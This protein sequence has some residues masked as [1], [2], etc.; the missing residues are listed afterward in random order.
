MKSAGIARWLAAGAVTAVA[1]A[2]GAT[3]RGPTHPADARA[4]ATATEKP[5]PPRDHPEGFGA[6]ARGGEGG[7][8]LLVTTLSDGGPGSLREALSA[9]GPRIVR[10]AVAGT[11][12]LQSR[13][14]VTSGRVTID[15]A[16]APGKG[17]TLL[18]HGIQFRGDCDDII[19]R[20]LRIRVLTGGA[21]GDA[22]LF[23]GNDGATVERVLVDHCSLM[24]A[25]DE[26]FNTW[27]RVRDL[28]CQWSIIA[29]AQLPHSK[30]W[31]SGV[32]S[33]RI[34]IHHCLFA[35]N[36]DRVPK[37]EG[38]VY[39]V[40]NN[41]FYNWSNNNAAKLEAGAKVN[42]VGNSFIPGP[43]SAPSKGCV[44]PAGAE[45]GTKVYLAGNVG[46]FTP[47]G[48]EPQWPNV[49][50]YDRV[51]GAWVEH[52]PAPEVFRSERPFVAP[53]IVAQPASA[54]YDLVLERAGARV[55]DADDARVVEDVRRRAGRVGKGRAVA[56]APGSRMG[57]GW[58][59]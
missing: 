43:Q 46:P 19:V 21:E 41:V 34:S 45:R 28:T 13:L 58:S 10:F 18:N 8:V 30:A 35:Q 39:D 24:W 1:L 44:F 12:A 31:L 7:C 48:R 23:W 4:A 52:R 51:G 22:L 29:E 27:G 54:A 42:L 36:A 40:V 17:I 25:T 9:Q 20:D 56:S 53:A 59:P 2:A 55:R 49:T 6:I 38:G 3:G 32:G 37:L 26:V 11:I 14:L 15:G 47:T 16:S 33:D 5:A 50:A 57:I